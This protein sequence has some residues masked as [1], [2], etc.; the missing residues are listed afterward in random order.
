MAGYLAWYPTDQYNAVL[1]MMGRVKPLKLFRRLMMDPPEKVGSINFDELPT[2]FLVQHIDDTA[3]L[4]TLDLRSLKFKINRWVKGRGDRKEAVQMAFLFPEAEESAVGRLVDVIGEERANF[5]RLARD[6]ETTIDEI[7]KAIDLGKAKLGFLNV[8]VYRSLP[9]GRWI[10]TQRTR[11]WTHGL[12][13]YDPEKGGDPPGTTIQSVIKGDKMIYEVNINDLATFAREGLAP[14]PESIQNDLSYS[15][16]PG[17]MLFIRLVSSRGVEGVIHLHN[18]VRKDE[19]M[20][21]PP[22]LPANVKDAKRVITELEIYFEEAA[23]AIEAVRQRESITAGFD[24]FAQIYAPVSP[25]DEPSLLTGNRLFNPAAGFAYPQSE[26]EYHQL[27]SRLVDGN[28]RFSGDAKSLTLGGTFSRKQRGM[29]HFSLKRR[30]KRFQVEVLSPRLH[31]QEVKHRLIFDADLV[32]QSASYDAY[33]TAGVSYDKENYYVRRL[34]NAEKVVFIRF[35]GWPVS[36]AAMQGYQMSYE[37]RDLYYAFIHFAMTH[38][39]YQRYGLTSYAIRE[40]ISSLLYTNAWRNRPNLMLDAKGQLKDYRFRMWV[41]AHSGRF[42]PF[43]AF[44][45]GFAGIDPAW[46][47]IAQAIFRDVHKRITPPEELVDRPDPVARGA[48]QVNGGKFPLALDD[49]VYPL[50]TRYPVKNGVV[51]FPVS[52]V[53]L[54]SSMQEVWLREIGGQEGVAGGN[55]LYFGGIVNLGR[56][57]EAKKREKQREREVGNLE[58]TGDKVRGWLVKRGK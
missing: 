14:D 50:H 4:P 53:D 37:G 57:R 6:P 19:G 49:G 36:F 31:A 10:R 48:V 28:G 35:N 18:R 46:D 34:F 56:I 45:R 20:E 27:I 1:R 47:P 51:E 8:A 54:H 17:Q 5:Q 40:G 58:M 55:G 15:K 11:H 38:G 26:A 9:G 13:K 22:L 16:G 33:G 39:L 23:R 21:P 25:K 2:S 32:S 7:F 42:T 44:A 24:R 43:Y 30:E 41:A 12:S 29:S 3:K 52:E